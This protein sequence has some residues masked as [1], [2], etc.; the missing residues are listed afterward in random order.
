M[1]SHE[2]RTAREYDRWLRQ[3]GLVSAGMRLLMSPPGQFLVNTPAFR[4]PKELDIRPDH[5]V[6]DIGCGRG[7]LLR[8]LAARVRFTVPPVGLDASLT[9]LRLGQRDAAAEEDG[10][11][12]LVAGAASA[13]PF[14][15]ATFHYILSAHMVKHVPDALLIDV[16]REMYRV[17]RPGG[18]AVVWDFAPVRSRLLDRWNRWVVTRGVS[19]AHFRTYR[20]LA[21][22]ARRA[23]FDW[24]GNAGLRP[25]LYPPIPRASI[26]LGKAPEGWRG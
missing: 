7:A 21:A 14:A 22:L 15:D 2:V 4:L 8:M 16:F 1:V 25:F 24:C 10:P 18:L 5:R 17:L 6:L 26:L 23:G 9:M 19:S 12:H 20:Q 13:L 3:P 11:L